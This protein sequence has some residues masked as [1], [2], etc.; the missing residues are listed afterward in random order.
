MDFVT[1]KSRIT[2]YIGKYKYVWIVL[3]VGVVLMMLPERKKDDA[4]IQIQAASESA[5][6][7]SIE[8]RL[9][10][11]L[12]HVAGAGKVKVML[13]VSQGERTIYQ[14]DTT[15]SQ[16]TDHT[17]SRTQTILIKD[18]DRS[19]NGLVHQRNPPTYQGAIILAQGADDPAVKLAIVEAVSDVTGLGADRIS[20][21]KMR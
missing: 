21:L 4:T 13:S 12:S 17:D 3:L 14:T 8:D 19:E 20:V 9:G 2:E 6:E 18:D 1:L 11:I 5:T 15:Y 7:F 10:E 16:T